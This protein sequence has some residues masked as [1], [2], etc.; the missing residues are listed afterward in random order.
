[1]EYRNRCH[2]GSQRNRKMPCSECIKILILASFD[3]PRRRS[4]IYG[5]LLI[6][7]LKKEN[8][9]EVCFKELPQKFFIYSIIDPWYLLKLPNMAMNDMMGEQGLVFPEYFL[10][11]PFVAVVYVQ[12]IWNESNNKWI[13]CNWSRSKFK[14]SCINVFQSFSWRHPTSSQCFL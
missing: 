3:T 11:Y 1:M 6:A 12:T 10:A 9:I 8:H 14:C 5:G 13:Q 2:H 4:Q 7:R